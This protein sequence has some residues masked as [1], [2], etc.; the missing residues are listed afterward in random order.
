[1]QRLSPEITPRE[2]KDSVQHSVPVRIQA[3]PNMFYSR[4][5]QQGA[6][7]HGEEVTERRTRSSFFALK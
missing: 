4:G 3:V 2:K 7:G 6:E 5:Q 1:V